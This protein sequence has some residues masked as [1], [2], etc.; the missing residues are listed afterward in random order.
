M[1]QLFRI[2][3]TSA[4][5]LALLLAFAG[6]RRVAAAERPN[7][8]LILADDLGYGD[9]GCYGQKDIQTPN[10]DRMAAEG[11]R[12]T[13]CYAGSTVCAPSRCCL[14]TGLHT[15]HAR[16][17]GNA[18]VPLLPGDVTVGELLKGQGYSTAIIG[19]WG[20]GEPGTTGVPNRQGF[21]SWFGY[22]NQVHA[23]NY[24]PEFLWKNEERYPLPNV[25]EHVIDG[26]R[27]SPGGVATKRVVYSHDL[28]SEEALAFLDR[29]KYDTFFL[30]LPYTIRT[31]TTRQATAAW[32]CPVTRPMRMRIGP[33]RRKG[34]PP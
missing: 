34:M 19:K 30:Y 23:H 14:M 5:S 25:V 32:R 27:V 13:D 20:L 31:P 4:V 7:I 33:R 18:R 29:H 9:L 21:D 17:R 1:R 10:L 28:F 22:L 6:P 3:V 11:M 16:I 2:L 24:Y 26:R 12:F 15:G 8:I